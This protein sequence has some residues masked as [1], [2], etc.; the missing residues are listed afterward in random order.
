MHD[1][2]GS[3]VLAVADG[4]LRTVRI[5]TG[6]EAD[7]HVEVVKGLAAGEFI[8]AKAGTFLSDG[9]AITPVPL[10]APRRSTEDLQAKAG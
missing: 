9:D 8:V 4:R 5:A 6:L 1:A 10:D 7:G 2:Q 3:Y